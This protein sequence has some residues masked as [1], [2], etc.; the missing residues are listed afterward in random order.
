MQTS[1]V[2]NSHFRQEEIGDVRPRVMGR[3]PHSK[4]RVWRRSE[5]VVAAFSLAVLVTT[6]LVLIYQAIAC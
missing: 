2:V 6:V 5:N 1:S 4:F 3:T